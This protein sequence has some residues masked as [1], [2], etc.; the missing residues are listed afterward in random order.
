MSPP[1]A[2]PALA[3]DLVEPILGWR[4]WSVVVRPDGT[5]ALGSVVHQ[6]VWP[7]RQ[8]LDA[9]CLAWRWRR[10]R[11]WLHRHDHPAPRV[12]CSCGIYATAAAARAL[13]YLSRE[14][15]L[16]GRPAFM[17]LGLVKLWGRVIQCERGWRAAHAYPARLYLISP[18]GRNPALGE[19]RV[20]AGLAAYGIPIDV[21]D[22]DATTVL[23]ALIAR[24]ETLELP[25]PP[26]LPSGR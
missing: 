15:A 3:P 24:Q 21:L 26:P 10:R 2:S 8:Q 14:A 5:V 6:V 19:Q 23:D 13:P 20:A 12:D 7:L 4:G 17:A 16:R 22:A 11:P 1:P 25:T 9:D 18:P